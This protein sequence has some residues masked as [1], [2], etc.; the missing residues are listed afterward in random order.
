MSLKL[1]Q[2]KP[3]A[4]QL[5]GQSGGSSEQGSLVEDQTVGRRWMMRELGKH[6]GQKGHRHPALPLCGLDSSAS[7]DLRAVIQ[8]DSINTSWGRVILSVKMPLKIQS[9]SSFEIFKKRL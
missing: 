5:G 7:S 4:G 3:V 2:H 6:T 9:F 8:R 1:T